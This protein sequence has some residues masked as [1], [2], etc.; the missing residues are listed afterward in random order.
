MKRPGIRLRALEPSDADFL[1]EVENDSCAWEYS[2]NYAPLSRRQIRDYALE[3]DADPFRSGQLRMIAVDSETSRPVGVA[4]FYNISPLHR[5]AFAGLYILPSMRSAGYGSSMLAE[6]LDYARNILCL[7]QL[8]AKVKA[9]NKVS[10]R[11]FIGSGFDLIATLPEWMAAP[12]NHFCDILVFSY[13][14]S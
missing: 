8:A 11:L 10:S 12:G 6:M 3:Y 7:H 1:F 9:G 2:D 5:R 4:D 14:F 13:V